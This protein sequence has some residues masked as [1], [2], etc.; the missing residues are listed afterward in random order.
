MNIKQYLVGI[1]IIHTLWIVVHLILVMNNQINPWKLG[2]YGMYTVPSPSFKIDV[3]GYDG[4]GNELAMEF[5]IE[6]EDKL[7][8]IFN[9][10]CINSGKSLYEYLMNNMM[11]NKGDRYHVSISDR[12]FNENRTGIGY[13]QFGHIDIKILPTYELVAEEV[14]CNK[15]PTTFIVNP[16]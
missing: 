6:F 1:F 3:T 12:R 10:G 15:S 7:Y 5:P 8:R 14:I 4:L 11:I 16:K 2:G 13:Y 9:A